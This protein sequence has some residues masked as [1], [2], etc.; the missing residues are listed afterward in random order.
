MSDLFAELAKMTAD[1]WRG[2]V[3][4]VLCMTVAGIATRYGLAPWPSWTG[5]SEAQ[6]R[7]DRRP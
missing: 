3:A 1:Q 5:S 4:C 2:D 6:A 7:V